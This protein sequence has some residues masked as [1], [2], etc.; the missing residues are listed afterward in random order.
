MAG[1]AEAQVVVEEPIVAKVDEVKPPETKTDAKTDKVT[2]TET[3]VEEVK[4]DAKVEEKSEEAKADA[5]IVYDI[6]APEGQELD[7]VAVSEFVEFAKAEK[8]PADLAQKIVEYGIKRQV[9]LEAASHKTLE[10]QMLKDEAAAIQQLKDDP[11]LGGANY[12]QTVNLASEGFKKFASKEE[13][14]FINATRLGNRVPMITLFRKVA[15]AMREDGMRGVKST[16]PTGKIETDEDMHR[17][18]YPSMYPKEE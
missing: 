10:A 5:E 16:T 8:L 11:L 17:A 12:E 3:K 6:K 2:T 15:L 7:P 18:M 9:S 1:T 13:M 4:A 14:E